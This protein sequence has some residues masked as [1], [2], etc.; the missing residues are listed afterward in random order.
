[1]ESFDNEQNSTVRNELDK[2]NKINDELREQK[3]ELQD[4]LKTL[5]E[6]RDLL[7]K[8]DIEQI[9]EIEEQKRKIIELKEWIEKMPC[10]GIEPVVMG[11]YE[12]IK[13]INEA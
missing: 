7:I 5:K 6:Q 2:V 12:R 9:E 11:I 3:V 4:E 10:F 8:S 13:K 1:M